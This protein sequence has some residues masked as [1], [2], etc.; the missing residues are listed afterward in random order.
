MIN[1]CD[2]RGEWGV[3]DF[4]KFS[5]RKFAFKVQMQRSVPKNL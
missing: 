3:L 1:Q 4:L 2:E 5:I